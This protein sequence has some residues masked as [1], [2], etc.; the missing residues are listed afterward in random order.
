MTAG[1]AFQEKSD[2]TALFLFFFGASQKAVGVSV[3]FRYQQPS[4]TELCNNEMLIGALKEL[5]LVL[6]KSGNHITS[7]KKLLQFMNTH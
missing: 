3:P 4:L 2:A 7:A 1:S 5:A 6:A